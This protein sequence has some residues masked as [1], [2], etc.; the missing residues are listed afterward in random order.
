[1]RLDLALVDR[2][3]ARSR[4]HARQLIE[5]DRVHV[6]GAVV[7]PSMRVDE[8][9]TINVF[10]DPYV[11]RGAHKLIH[12][13]NESGL[14]ISGR[15]LDAGASTGGFT[16]VLL[17]SGAQR[18]YAVDVGHDQ[19]VGFL[20]EDPRVVIREGLNLRDLSLD[21]LESELVDCVVCDISFISVR[22]ILAQ[23]LSVLKPDGVALILVKP[24]FEVG[25]SALDSHGVVMDEHKRELAVC[26]VVDHAQQLGWYLQW[27]APS[28][29][30]G[31]KGNQE[32]F[33]LFRMH[34]K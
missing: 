11:S 13:L 31:E 10:T 28:V 23:I 19:I 1:M 33:C 14:T 18:V 25:R 30:T 3:L 6:P 15:V 12:A 22:L 8:T 5:L 26:E 32:T 2:G 9:T 21:D 27:S 34:P 24:Q 4:S 7:K 29:L 17:E 20:R 16:Q